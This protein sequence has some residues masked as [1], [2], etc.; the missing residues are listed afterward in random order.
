LKANWFLLLDI[1]Q[2]CA[3]LIVNVL[4]SSLATRLGYGGEYSM[5]VVTL[6][7]VVTAL[8]NQPNL[9]S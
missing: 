9:P 7:H 4:R 1:S 6:D 2:E 3:V 8:G 5:D